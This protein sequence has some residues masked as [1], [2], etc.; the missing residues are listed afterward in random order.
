[1]AGKRRLW[2]AR[3]FY[4]IELG[5]GYANEET[6]T[7]Q[8]HKKFSNFLRLSEREI[9]THFL[10]GVQFMKIQKNFHITF[11]DTTRC[12]RILRINKPIKKS[13]TGD[14]S[15][16]Y[17]C[18]SPTS[19]HGS[20][21]FRFSKPGFEKFGRFWVE[22][23]GRGYRFS[24]LMSLQSVLKCCSRSQKGWITKKTPYTWI[25]VNNDVID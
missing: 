12:T 15:T 1:M 3:W 5:Q 7:I 16:F 24:A 4:Y 20:N 2:A 14:N 22:K 9:T 19:K 21:S 17:S 23:T 10:R 11:C 8:P 6:G 18:W 25:R 13:P